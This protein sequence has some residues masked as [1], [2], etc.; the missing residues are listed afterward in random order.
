MLLGCTG[1]LLCGPAWSHGMDPNS[2]A[3]STISVWARGTDPNPFWGAV[4]HVLTAPL[5]LAALLA[6]IAALTGIENRLSLSVAVTTAISAAVTA[7]ITVLIAS[8]LVDCGN[9]NSMMFGQVET[10]RSEV[11]LCA[12]RNISVLWANLSQALAPS[13]AMFLGLTALIGWRHTRYAALGLGLLA[14]GVTGLAAQLDN[15]YWQG[16]LG[17]MV[18]TAFITACGLIAFRWLTNL[19]RAQSIVPIARRVLGSWVMAMSLLLVVLAVRNGL[20]SLAWLK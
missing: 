6:L 12:I 8:Y 1:F 2:A 15:G 19:P 7:L 3:A 13:G 17:L 18:C 20:N 16:V 14:G 4:L 9:P 5:A 10:I 11:G